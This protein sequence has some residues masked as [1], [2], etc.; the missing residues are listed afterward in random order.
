[1][2]ITDCRQTSIKME[3]VNSFFVFIL[4]LIVNSKIEFVY[5]QFAEKYH[6]KNP[7]KTSIP[8]PLNEAHGTAISN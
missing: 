7:L 8:F 1:M 3:D 4:Y 5:L 2:Y 6:S